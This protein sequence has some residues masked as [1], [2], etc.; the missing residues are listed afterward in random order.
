MRLALDF[1]SRTGAHFIHPCLG[2][3]LIAGQGTVAEEILEE[4]P[5]LGTLVLPVGGGGLLGGSGALLRAISPATSI[6]G[7]QSVLTA[8]MA[9][10]LAAGKV[11]PIPSEPTLADGLAG[12]IDEYALQV[13]QRSLDEIVL[14]EEESIARAIR[15]LHNEEGVTSEGSGA[16]GVAALLD[17]RLP[18]I[19]SPVAVIVS[20]GNID[21]A[22]L[23]RIVNDER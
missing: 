4:L 8:A 1:A 20:G 12:G 19:T 7:A 17:G 6:V 22:R 14:V 3:D 23:S 5:Q 13:G 21:Q 15:W 16:V 18:N 2:D 9:R 11:V 10:S